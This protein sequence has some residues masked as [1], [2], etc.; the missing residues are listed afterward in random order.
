MGV[1]ITDINT[2]IQLG[3]VDDIIKAFD[4]Y[5]VF[6]RLIPSWT[7][8]FRSACSIVDEQRAFAKISTLAH[9]H[10]IFGDDYDRLVYVY[11]VC[12]LAPGFIGQES[13][14]DSREG[15]YRYFNINR[16]GW[17]TSSIHL[18]EDYIAKMQALYESLRPSKNQLATAI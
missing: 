15:R 11:S 14:W 18:R 6:K 12:R 1:L 17:T 2:F 7:K 9:D 13:K 8:T 16:Y 4:H 3:Q 5:S 10:E